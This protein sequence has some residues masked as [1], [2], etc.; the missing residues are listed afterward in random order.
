ML[1]R[2]EIRRKSFIFN[3]PPSYYVKKNLRGLLSYKESHL[4]SDYLIPN[5]TLIQR[6]IQTS[7]CKNIYSKN[8]HL[9]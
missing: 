2:K 3:G 5:I 4:H 6:F 7:I 1:K 8:K 9:F